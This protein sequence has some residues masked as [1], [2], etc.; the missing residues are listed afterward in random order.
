M[1]QGFVRLFGILPKGLMRTNQQILAY[2][3]CIVSLE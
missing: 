1:Y 2:E 3:F